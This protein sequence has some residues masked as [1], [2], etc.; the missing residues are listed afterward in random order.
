MTTMSQI[1][2]KTVNTLAK[3]AVKVWLAFNAMQLNSA[4][5]TLLTNIAFVNQD[6]M[7]RV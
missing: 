2:V 4:Y 5:L 7:I 3:L 1:F 6:I